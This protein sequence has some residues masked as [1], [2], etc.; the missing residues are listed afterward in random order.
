MRNS[1][2]ASDGV[3]GRVMD[4]RFFKL[5]VENDPD[6]FSV[7]L[8]NKNTGVEQNVT[9]SKQHGTAAEDYIQ[10]IIDKNYNGIITKKHLDAQLPSDWEFIHYNYAWQENRVYQ[11]LYYNHNANKIT[12]IPRGQISEKG[13]FFIQPA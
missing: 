10:N 12:V 4:S 8:R 9:V 6:E 2:F 7:L 5:Y 3:Q 1:A 11:N 13:G